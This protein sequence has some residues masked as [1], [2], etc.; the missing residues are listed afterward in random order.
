MPIDR[1]TLLA[2][3][4]A[5]ATPSLARAA[6]PISTLGLDAAQLGVR[7]GSPD[8]QTKAL[9]RAIDQAAAA[10]VPLALAPGVYRAGDLALP[11]GAQIVG[12]RGATRLV[13]T[14]ARPLF[15]A[16]QAD[17][18]TLDALMLDGA[19]NQLP[20][21]LGLVALMNGR[22]V[23]ITDCEVSNANGHGISLEGVAGEILSTTIADASDVAIH[24]IDARG[25]T[26]ARNIV[27]AAGNNGIVILRNVAG[28]DA[29]MVLD[30]RIEDVRNAAGGSGQFGNGVNAFR[31]A[32]VIVRG[33]RIR[34][35]A[36]S[37]VRGNT[38]SAI[39]IV[40]NSCSDIGEVALYSEFGFEGAVIANNT[41][42]GAQTGVSVANFNE[43][44]RIAVVQG[45]IFRNLAPR[46][47][48]EGDNG[49]GIY[50]E[51]DSAVTG[52]VVES[53]T[54]AGIMA[55]WGPYLRDVT[56][57]GNVVRA[58][59]IGIGISVVPGGGGAVIANNSIS[60]ARRGAILGM[61][62]RDVVTGDLT[63]DGAARYAQLAIGGNRVN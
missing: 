17:R 19:G 38:A 4:A 11:A 12:I 50:V 6:A 25:L 16:P 24:S 39:E 9:Q 13:S 3:L 31:A 26:I 32:H 51:A 29:T 57:T 7:A 33:N 27:H 56:I 54:F 22:G 61:D 23:R 59:A 48:S 20:G 8:D 49:I 45:N 34:G 62:H 53:A 42:V 1:R 30:N 18:V 52:N 15:T 60:G 43:G 40:G 41:V 28:E 55:G 2:G 63:K 21:G 36:F 14:R 58:A 37:A 46:G 44:G 5:T 47:R 35:C 10:R